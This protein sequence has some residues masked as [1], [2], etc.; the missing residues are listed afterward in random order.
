[1]QNNVELSICRLGAA[2]VH[3]YLKVNEKSR[4]RWT[5]QVRPTRLR[6]TAG[7]RYSVL[8]N[9]LRELR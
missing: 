5:W 2:D 4:D 1:M 7:S 3:D 9:K 6:T 8:A